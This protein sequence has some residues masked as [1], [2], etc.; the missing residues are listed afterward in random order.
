MVAA[1]EGTY[2]IVQYL[3]E[4]GAD[5]QLLTFVSDLHSLLELRFTF[6]IC[7]FIYSKYIQCLH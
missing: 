1:V 3:L 4:K 7:K 5:P 6:Q 2:E